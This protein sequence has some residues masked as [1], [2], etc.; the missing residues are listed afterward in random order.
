MAIVL[1]VIN[2]WSIVYRIS[3][4]YTQS[5]WEAAIVVDAYRAAHGQPV[6]E[7]LDQGGHATHMYGPIITQAVAEIR[8]GLHAL[9]RGQG[10][11]PHGV[12]INRLEKEADRLHQE[13]VRRLF[14]EEGDPMAVFKWKEA[15]DLLEDAT[16]RCEDAANVIETILLKH[17]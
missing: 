4:P 6:Y 1:I 10:F 12:E 9:E 7:R 14:A 15:L 5:P 17:G 8:R 13:A 3:L 2:C 16:D 11:I